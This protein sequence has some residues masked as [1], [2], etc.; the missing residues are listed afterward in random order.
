MTALD[1]IDTIVIVMM[2]NRSFDHALGY[3]SLNGSQ[4]NGL[5]ADPAWQANFIN[6]YNGKQYPIHALSPNGPAISD[7]PHD[8]AP[9]ATQINT[10][11]VPGGSPELGGF[12]Q[13]YATRKPAPSN[14]ADVMG[15]CDA[16]TV[17]TFDFLAKHF[18]VCDNWFAPLPSGTQA[19]RLM[20]MAGTS[21]ISDNVQGLSFLPDQPLVYDWLRQRGIPWC[22]YQ[23]GSF[24]PFFSMMKEWLPEIVLSLTLPLNGA[25]GNFRRY[26]RFADDWQGNSILPKVIFIEPEYTDGPHDTANDDHCPTGMAGGQAFIAD[27]YR[28]LISNPTRWKETLLI[29]T[30]DEHGG[31]FDHVA[32]LDIAAD[33]AGYSFKTSGLR[34]PA[35]LVSPYVTPGSVFSGRL[36][37][38]A[39]LQMLAE[40]FDA[41]KKYSDAV[42]ARNAQLDRLASALDGQPVAQPAPAL[43]GA[44][45][46][47]AAA[48]FNGGVQTGVSDTVQ[49]FHNVALQVARDHP[50][51]LS[52]PQ[53]TGLA[54][55]VS[56]YGKH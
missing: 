39:V 27:I 48:A 54:E 52:S 50:Q 51:L 12:V 9:I 18:T 40:K 37:H 55:Y 44:P 17:P 19:N 26:S 38:T 21:L 4:V 42:T 15:Y 5:S 35:F 3:L 41:Q 11:C 28:T 31:F 8:R 30:Y 53:W 43:A 1:Q 46:H 7:P 34:V 47:A 36:D 20:A 45:I 14:L 13:S 10:P 33:I 25:G 23:S 24:F 56:T 2:E 22:V 16:R 6:V 32:P 49:G 29:V